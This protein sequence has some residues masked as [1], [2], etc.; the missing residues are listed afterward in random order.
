MLISKFRG[1]CD[2]DYL[3]FFKFGEFVVNQLWPA[4]L[5]AIGVVLPPVVTA[6]VN[7]KSLAGLLYS[8][9]VGFCFLDEL[10]A[11]SSVVGRDF[12]AS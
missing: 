3:V 9:S 10:E 5:I 1:A 8:A 6:R 7:G 11:L 4:P 2:L 12:S